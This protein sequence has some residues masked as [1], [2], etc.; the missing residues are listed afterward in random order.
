M[1]PL[2]DDDVC[3]ARVERTVGRD[4]PFLAVDEC[5]QRLTGREGAPRVVGRERET[6]QRKWR[7]W[8]E[9]KTRR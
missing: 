2:P 4:Q 3:A 5:T 9:K 6:A 7:S 8:W 1:W